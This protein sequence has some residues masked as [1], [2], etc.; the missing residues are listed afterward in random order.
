MKSILA[1]SDY[2]EF[3]R[4]HVTQK[5]RRNGRWSIG[6]WA[7][8]LKLGSTTSLTMIL[9]G[10]RNP[11]PIITEKLI[12]YFN[13]ELRERDY[14]LDL[15][16][17]AKIR[18]Q[19]PSHERMKSLLTSD[20]RKLGSS[21][22]AKKIDLLT[23]MKISDWRC[24][25]LRQ[26]THLKDFVGSPKA[27]AA[28]TIFPT[29]S[30][31]IENAINT[32]LEVGL[33]RKS[34]NGGLKRVSKFLKTDDDIASEGLKRFHEAMIEHGRNAIRKIPVNEREIIGLTLAVRRSQIEDAK[35]LI[36]NFIEDFARL[37]GHK[38]A[39]QV[40]QLNIQFFPLTR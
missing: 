27:I 9:N 30:L 21:Y 29:S 19:G 8:K 12:Q 33:L 10:Q 31:E 13:F 4:N 28:R 2:R 5:R 20:L 32:L 16:E 34:A 35:K 36:R 37:G 1:Y 7:R 24:F 40:C 3:L 25:M 11:G 15:I 38:E 23:F 26:M 22:L 17:I 39:D 14:F 18:Q 6:V